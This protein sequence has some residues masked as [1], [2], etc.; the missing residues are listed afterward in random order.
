MLMLLIMLSLLCVAI[1]YDLITNPNGSG[2]D[3]G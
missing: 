3:I 1:T 2:P